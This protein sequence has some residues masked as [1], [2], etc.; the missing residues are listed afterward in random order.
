MHDSGGF[1][2]AALFISDDD[3]VC[4]HR[5][6]FRATMRLRKALRKE[7][8]L[9]FEKRAFGMEGMKDKGKRHMMN[10]VF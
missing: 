3:D 8:L 2:T 7:V 6:D 1:T 9:V 5:R 10:F 4:A